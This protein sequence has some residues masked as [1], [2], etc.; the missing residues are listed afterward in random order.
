MVNTLKFN[1]LEALKSSMNLFWKK[2]YKATSTRDLQAATSLKPGSL[3]GT[4]KSKE[5]LLTE[6]LQYY[7][8]TLLRYMESCKR[9]HDNPLDALQVF[10][11]S[12]LLDDECPPSNLCFIYKTQIELTGTQSA[13]ITELPSK[14]FEKWFSDI[15][16]EAKKKG[17]L[18]LTENTSLLVKKFQTQL[19]GWRGYLAMKNDAVFIRSE[20]NQYFTELSNR[21]NG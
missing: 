7:S 12:V 10:V 14:K 21:L 6:T 16:E 1:R 11:L 13:H 20:I 9:N 8:E 15:F 4:F 3:Y 17:F 2:G 18:S 5:A 19:L